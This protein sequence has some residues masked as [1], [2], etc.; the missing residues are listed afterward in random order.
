[1]RTTDEGLHR[2]RRIPVQD[3]S[4]VPDASVCVC[5]FLFLLLLK[6]VTEL[7]VRED[8]TCSAKVPPHLS[9]SGVP[10]RVTSAGTRLHAHTYTQLKHAHSCTSEPVTVS[11]CAYTFLCVCACVRVRICAQ[12]RLLERGSKA[13]DEQRGGA[14][15]VFCADV[16]GRRNRAQ[17]SEV[18][19]DRTIDSAPA[20]ITKQ[21][22]F[23]PWPAVSSGSNMYAL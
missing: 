18:T 16:R 13:R 15:R 12:P 9:H 19:A 7:F 3:P 8:F 23:F 5:A 21:R 6:G 10:K 4:G 2:R 11:V 17:E 1:M 20:V 22:C 14:G